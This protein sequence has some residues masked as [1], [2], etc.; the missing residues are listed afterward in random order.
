MRT[1][2]K[3][4][5]KVRSPDMCVCL[6]V[7]AH[8]CFSAQRASAGEGLLMPCFRRP[9]EVEMSFLGLITSPFSQSQQTLTTPIPPSPTKPRR[10]ADISPPSP[11]VSMRI[12]KP[13]SP[14]CQLKMVFKKFLRVI[15]IFQTSVLLIIKVNWRWVTYQRLGSC[16][17]KSRNKDPQ[18]FVGVGVYRGAQDNHGLV[19][20]WHNSIKKKKY[21]CAISFFPFF[22]LGS[23]LNK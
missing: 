3:A 1:T 7:C 15:G 22:F 12:H 4:P 21:K 17:I 10:S 13:Y 20:F 19:C 23:Q 14:H 11:V 18:G 5:V 8:P 6:C 9:L 2:L 16:Y